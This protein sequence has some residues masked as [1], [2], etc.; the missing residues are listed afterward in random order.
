MKKFTQYINEGIENNE[1]EIKELSY[2]DFINLCDIYEQINYKN[3]YGLTICDI[4]NQIKNNP[5]L[6]S[7]KSNKYHFLSAIK[8]GILIGVFYKQ[9]IG[10]PDIYDDGY[11]IS[12]GAGKKLLR[13]MKTI[14]SFT[15]F[16]NI[17]NIP[18]MKSQLETGAEI[19]C[20][21]DNPPNKP[22]GSYN[23]NISNDMKNLLIDNFYYI[24][25][26]EKFYFLDETG[27][28]KKNELKNFL[29]S[30]NKITIIDKQKI[31]EK[32]KIYFLFKKG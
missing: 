29:L 19:I 12:K 22:N 9:L 25:N 32:I 10:N 7:N 11:I 18:S 1:I 17:S 26:N 8:N 21:T 6:F 4:V 16:S 27:N 15:T 30:N 23:K 20:I 31:G 2:L 3:K 5:K 13:K 24:S 14:G 28:L